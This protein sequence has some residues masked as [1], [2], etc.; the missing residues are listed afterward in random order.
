M[1]ADGVAV[2]PRR[3]SGRVS[4]RQM[5]ERGPLRADGPTA[6]PFVA[7]DEDRDRRAA[8][9]DHRHRCYADPRPWA[10][11]LAHQSAYCLTN[12]FPACPA[13]QDWARRETAQADKP[14][15][16]IPVQR[17]EQVD[18]VDDLPP[19]HEN[20][21][22]WAEGPGWTGG[23]PGD[24]LSAWD[25]PDAERDPDAV[26]T[27]TPPPRNAPVPPT[28]AEVGPARAGRGEAIAGDDDGE[29]DAVEPP[30]FLAGRAEGR[31][32]DASLP[33]PGRFIS[34]SAPGRDAR[35][36]RGGG[37]ARRVTL[38]RDDR[39]A[40]RSDSPAWETPRRSEAYPVLRRRDGMP[41]IPPVLLALAAVLV[42]AVLLFLLPSI[43]PNLGGGPGGTTAPTGTAAA[44]VGDA[45]PTTS[46]APSTPSTG[47]TY[48]VRSGDTLTRIANQFGITI[49]ELRAA[50]PQIANPDDIA[51]DDV[52][53]IPAPGGASPSAPAATSPPPP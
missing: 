14:K 16:F 39:R 27:G 19:R 53:N 7:F 32:A 11:A 43:L 42:A 26:D 37:Q 8:D 4:S 51:I 3:V 36:V 18:Y 49:E 21:R 28:A 1:R 9:P 10:P 30:A 15:G 44:T 25:D 6:C 22:E 47:Q 41:T 5:T 17:E 45:T 52:I 31:P 38:E 34:G 13:F 48:V 20:R 12:G 24:Q 35:D 23:G 29:A 50:N 2:G 40:G 33:R 46:V